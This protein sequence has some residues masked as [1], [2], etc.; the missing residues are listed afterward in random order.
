MRYQSREEKG[1]VTRFIDPDQ[2]PQQESCLP[3]V[4]WCLIY[5]LSFIY[6]LLGLADESTVQ[7]KIKAI[8]N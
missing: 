5:L 7:P 1:T 3:I 4:N 8:L 6:E 2:D